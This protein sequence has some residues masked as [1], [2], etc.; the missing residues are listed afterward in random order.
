MNVEII[1]D[2]YDDIEKDKFKKNYPDLFQAIDKIYG[3]PISIPLEDLKT[4]FLFRHQN[5]T[6]A[7]YQSFS[8]FHK[9]LAKYWGYFDDHFSYDPHTKSFSSTHI[10]NDTVEL[11]ESIG[12]AGALAISSKIFLGVTQADWRKIPI[13]KSKDLDF[14]HLASDLNKY[15]VVES[16]GSITENNRVKTS[17]ISNHKSS[18]LDKKSDPLF[19]E[20]YSKN[21]DVCYGIITVADMSNTLR[22]WIVDPPTPLQKMNPTKYKLLS[23]LYYYNDFIRFISTRSY[24]SLLLPSRIKDVENVTNWTDLNDKPIVD[25]NFRKITLS[26]YFINSRSNFTFKGITYIGATYLVDE[27]IYFTGLSITLL[28]ILINQNFESIINY[29]TDPSSFPA[30]ATVRLGINENNRKLYQSLNLITQNFTDNY[31]YAKTTLNI[32]RASSGLVFG[33]AK[34][35]NLRNIN[36]LN[37]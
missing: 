4:F 3:N 27:M 7:N 8:D 22:S 15:L 14:K 26:Y 19:R 16:K 2:Y 20:K 37:G 36:S 6:L 12:V 24:L 9:K 21:R 10:P 34:V 11:A 33:R 13:L 31:F 32:T 23:R 17:K 18:I 1:F 35:S 30:E 29:K 25:Y 28:N 5:S